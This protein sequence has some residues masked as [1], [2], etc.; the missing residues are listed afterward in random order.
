MEIEDFVKSR[1]SVKNLK[2]VPNRKYTCVLCGNPF[3][4]PKT[5]QFGSFL[6]EVFVFILS[7][8]A[9]TLLFGVFGVFMAIIIMFIL[10]I[11]RM[12]FKKKVCPYC[13]SENFIKHK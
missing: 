8:I 12:C 5:K 13:Q 11:I 1:P 6:L 9:G 2:Q 10:S 4:K 7:L 3:D